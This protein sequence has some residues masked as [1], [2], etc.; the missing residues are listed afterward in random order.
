MIQSTLIHLLVLCCFVPIATAESTPTDTADKTQAIVDDFASSEHP[1][2]TARRGEW[3][4]ENHEATCVADLKLFKQF[5]N[6]GPILTWPYRFS[7]GT[8]EMEI[9]PVDCQR[10]VFT[11][12]GDGH[13]FRVT[14]ADEREEAPAGKSR[15]PNRL[16][17]WATKSSKQNKG[18]TIVPD[19]MP[20]LP[21]VNNQWVKLKLDVDGDIAKLRIGDFESEIKHPALAREK[22]NVTITFAFGKMSVRNVRIQ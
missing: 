20:N 1:V 9:K 8:V 11:L 4:F 2:R 3:L 5:N 7:E 22:T 10:V 15:V 16:I 19:G 17:A 12:N 21:A 18:D 13:V 14:L 6:H